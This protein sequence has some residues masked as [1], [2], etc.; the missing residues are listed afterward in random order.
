MRQKRLRPVGLALVALGLAAAGCDSPSEPVRPRAASV[1]AYTGAEAQEAEAGAQVGQVPAVRVLDGEGRPLRG[2]VVDFVVTA[3]GGS[4]TRPQART[5]V[6]GVASAGEWRLGSEGENALEARVGELAPVVFRARALSAAEARPFRVD[7]RIVG[8]IT[9]RQQLA[10]ESAVSRWEAVLTQDMPDV[11]LQVAA[12]SCFAGQPALNALVDDLVLYV[13]F[14]T[15]DGPG[16]VLGEAGPCYVRSESRLPLVGYLKLDGADLARMETSGTLDDVVL[17]EI[18]HV[19][20]IGTLWDY[21]NLVQGAGTEDPRFTGSNAVAAYRSLGGLEVGIA[22][23][24]TGGDGTRD[25]HW[26]ESMFGNELMTGYI[27]SIPNPLSA[28]TIASL[29]DLGY[30]ASALTAGQYTLG[31]TYGRAVSEAVDLRGRERVHRPR[32]EVNRRGQ[33]GKLPL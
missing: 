22:V 14:K 25:S 18:G 33:K 23:E 6:A 24:N 27:G 32:Y 8:S 9:A 13:E 10:V 16:S 31:G 30:G 2:A 7:V 5:D 17:H 11:M 3:G 1:V 20:G 4:V 21:K 28:M 19:L 15:I 12:G 29:Q 26:R